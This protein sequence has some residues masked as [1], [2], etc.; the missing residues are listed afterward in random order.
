MRDCVQILWLARSSTAGGANSHCSYNAL[1]KDESGS[2][3][4]AQIM[5]FDDA[6]H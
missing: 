6:W 3:A 5:A 4:E 1:F 2:E